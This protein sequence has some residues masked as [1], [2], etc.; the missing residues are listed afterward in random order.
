MRRF[1]S[2][3]EAQGEHAPE[4]DSLKR[5]F[6]FWE[7]GQRSVKLPAYQRAFSQIYGMPLETLGFLDSEAGNEIAG[8]L[9]T[10]LHLY[11]VDR[12]LVEL[13]RAQTQ[14]LR[15][16]DR[17]LGTSALV[18]QA[19]AQTAQL[20]KV[21]RQSMSGER[22]ELARAV[23]ESA[24]LA[25]WMN[26]DSGDLAQAWALHETA[27]SAARESDDPTLLAHVQAQQSVVLLDAK[28]APD[29][30]TMVRAARASVH[31]TAPP[32]MRAWL[33]AAQAEAHAATGDRQEME[34]CMHDAVAQLAR[35]DGSEQ[36]PHLML[37]E[38]HLA[39]WWGSCLVRL[40]DEE[41]IDHLEKA[42]DSQGDSVRAA[43][44]LHADLALGK[45][46]AGRSVEAVEHARQAAAMAD[47]YGSARHKRRVSGLLLPAQGEDVQ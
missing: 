19:E 37:T 4:P 25:A 47:R 44:A 24:E 34:R 5:M 27:A 39:R 46:A 10:N 23:G 11:E 30:L 13:F 3:V 2:A 16:L 29:A 21:L 33:A 18:G 15:D 1:R 6:V 43:T 45:E 28:R 35:S 20:E 9:A 14:G 42:L 8:R 32:L 36:L 41:A 26:L 17:R 12:G 38:G 31:R 40:G 22:R 7:K